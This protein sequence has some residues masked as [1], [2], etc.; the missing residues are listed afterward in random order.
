MIRSNLLSYIGFLFMLLIGLA[1]CTTEGKPV[2]E[3]RVETN[4]TIKTAAVQKKTASYTLSL[5]GEL[6]PFAQVQLY[7]KVRGFIRELYVDRGSQVKK[8]QLLAR[9][10]APE[11]TQQY[12]AASAKQ[13][14][15]LERLQYSQQAYNRLKEAAQ[16]TGAVAAI[17]LE[18][19]EAKLM[20]DSA[21]Y[22]SLK[23]EM[24]AARQLASY[25]EIRAPFAGV[26]SNRSISTGALVGAGDKPLFT[27]AQQ[28]K[29]RLTI[30]IPEK[31][32]R[33][34][35]DST[36][37]R[38]RLSNYPNEVFTAHFSRSSG[39]LDESLRSLMVEFDVPNQDNKLSGG[40]YV[41]AEVKFQR[42]APSLWVP[43]SSL[44]HAT[45][46]TFVLKVVDSTVQRII[47]EEGIRQDELTEIY[48]PLQEGELVVL[49]GSEELREGSK[50]QIK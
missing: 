13:R 6:A 30:A 48:G 20:G 34:L 23:A 28:D 41:Q 35:S 43:A 5:P 22:L 12:M 7:S 50:V 38:Y 25:L 9:L 3:A 4:P 8:G 45:S 40:E 1:G 32:A 46:G 36:E 49:K 15:V 37:V 27:L 44:V 42:H 11:I 16:T 17:E 2:A 18:Q 10:E 39:V 33:A 14:E 29:L 26:I 19:A 24:A 31:H 47:V 21:S